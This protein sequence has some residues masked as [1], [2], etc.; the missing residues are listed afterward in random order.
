MTSDQASLANQQNRGG[1]FEVGRRRVQSGNNQ[2]TKQKALPQ[3]FV[4]GQTMSKR[5]SM[6]FNQTT[7]GT[8]GGAAI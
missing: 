3:K 2:K 8:G 5:S 4:A 1:G 7:V 6:L